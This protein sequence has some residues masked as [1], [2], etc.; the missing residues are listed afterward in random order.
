MNIDCLYIDTKGNVASEG[1]IQSIALSVGG[2][3]YGVTQ[4]ELSFNVVATNTDGTHRLLDPSEYTV[5]LT[6]GDV[7]KGYIGFGKYTF[8]ATLKN[9]ADFK[10]TS[11]TELAEYK[12]S[13]VTKAYLLQDGDKVYYVL[14]FNNVGYEASDY[15]FFNKSTIYS[16]AKTESTARTMTFYFDVTDW[17]SA[18][19]IWPHLTVAGTNYVN[20]ANANGD[21]RGN[22][23]EF[24]NGETLTVNGKTYTISSQWSMPVLT[25]TEG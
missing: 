22:Q 15:V 5:E 18:D 11:E 21:I 17:T 23:L 3:A 12:Q 25:I 16:V 13:L 20:G 4:D 9:N 8:T 10:T 19:S 6:E 24:T 7:S 14:E 1:E 2:M